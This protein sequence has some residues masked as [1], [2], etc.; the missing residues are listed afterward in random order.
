MQQP[1]ALV[2]LHVEVHGYV[3]TCIPDEGLGHNVVV[4]CVLWLVLV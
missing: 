2:H 4:Q 1:F 3:H